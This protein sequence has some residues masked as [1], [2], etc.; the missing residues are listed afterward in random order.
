VKIGVFLSNM[1]LPWREALV[2]AAEIGFDGVQITVAGDYLPW[3]PTFSSTTE[4][5]TALRNQGLEL[6]ALA[7]GFGNCALTDRAERGRK[8]DHAKRVL[9]FALELDTRIVTSHVGMI[10]EDLGTPEGR[11]MI[12]A[13]SAVAEHGQASGCTLAMETGPEPPEQMLALLQEINNPGLAV[14]YDPSNLLMKGFDWLGG[15]EVLGD[16]IVHTHAKDGVR[17]PDGRG[18]QRPLGEGEV[19]FDAWVMALRKFGFDGYLTIERESG[20]DRVGD[21][22]RGFEFLRRYCVEE[23]A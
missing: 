9:D 16:F 20:E 6:S 18:E 10:P 23:Q 12:A 21:I 8:I 13:L 3:P 15:V 19:D 22:I 14:N 7:G 2:K 5:R 1:G 17:L 11:A 4:L